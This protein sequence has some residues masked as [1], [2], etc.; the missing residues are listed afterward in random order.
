MDPPASGIKCSYAGVD[1]ELLN[2]IQLVRHGSHA[3]RSGAVGRG[4]A[5]KILA[6]RGESKV[7]GVDGLKEGQISDRSFTRGSSSTG[8]GIHA[9]QC[10]SKD[11][12]YLV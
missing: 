11:T 12:I 4:G 3:V 5:A 8:A 7:E 2:L 9:R 1:D 6:H 10:R